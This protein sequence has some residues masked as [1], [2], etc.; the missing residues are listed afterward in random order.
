MAACALRPHKLPD[1]LV[2][3]LLSPPA[4]S[5]TLGS[6][7]VKSGCRDLTAIRRT[8]TS[9]LALQWKLVLSRGAKNRYLTFV[10]GRSVP[11]SHAFAIS[12][13]IMTSLAHRRM[14]LHN[15]GGHSLHPHEPDI[16]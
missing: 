15:P 16:L 13:W 5:R 12:C 1:G 9:G 6:N 8:R 10:G 2:S 14:G 11:P 3:D 7:T 4:L